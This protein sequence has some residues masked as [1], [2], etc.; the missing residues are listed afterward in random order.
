M[1]V[2]CV[3]ENLVC[4]LSQAVR[5]LEAQTPDAIAVRVLRVNV[6]LSGPTA[7]IWVRAS[8]D[9]KLVERFE[10]EV[11]RKGGSI[12]KLYSNR[13]NTVYRVV[14]HDCP[15]TRLSEFNGACPLLM[16]PVGLMNKTVVITPKG[17]LY[18]YIAASRK[19]LEKLDSMGCKVVLVHGIDEYDYMLSEKQELALIYAYLMGY[20][21]FP[22]KTSLKALAGKLGLSVSTLAELLRRAEA[23]VI[24]AFVRHELPHYLVGIVLSRGKYYRMLEDKLSNH[25]RRRR[26]G[27]MAEASLVS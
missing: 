17:V 12:Q 23:K 8:G 18:E 21:G 16:A 9:S 27:E 24:E 10:E 3:N 4:P 13:F 7:E 5:D 26:G 6:D 15:C 20:Y 1:V 19:S 2:F 11:R 22:R 25:R 14:F